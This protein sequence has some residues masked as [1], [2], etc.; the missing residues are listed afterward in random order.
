MDAR[1]TDAQELELADGEADAVIRR[2]GLMLVPDPAR[3]TADVRRVLC[4]GGR[5]A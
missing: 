5:F 1:V 3:D 2:L 4:P